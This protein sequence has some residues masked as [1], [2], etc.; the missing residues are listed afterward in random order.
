MRWFELRSRT[1]SDDE[2][3]ELVRKNLRMMER[4][5]PW[6]IA[7]YVGCL[8]ILGYVV[9]PGVVKMMQNLTMWSVASGVPVWPF[10][11]GFVSGMGM[12]FA[13]VLT[14]FGPLFGFVLT[15]MPLQN[16]R[17]LLKYHDEIQ[18]RETT[19]IAEAPDGDKHPSPP[20]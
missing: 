8:A 1:L 10:V 19:A 3:I 11:P 17:L 2:Y 6:I 7:F 18:R 4:F 16:D 14:F 20:L 13:M 9:V 15:L 5:R 12:G